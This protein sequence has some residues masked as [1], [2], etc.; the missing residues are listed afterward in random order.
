MRSPL[1]CI[2]GSFSS[3]VFTTYSL[4]LRFFEHSVLPLL[5]SAGVRNVIIFCDE[6]LGQNFSDGTPFPQAMRAMGILYGIKVDTGAKPCPGLPGE[7]V[8]EGLDGLAGRL[9]RYAEMGA[10]FA[11]WRAVFTVSPVTPTKGAIRTNAN[12]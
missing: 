4:N 10:A 6:T 7:K 5:H 1:E 9:S 2:A 8:T 11:K 3:A 12:A